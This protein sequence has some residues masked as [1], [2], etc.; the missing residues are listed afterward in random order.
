MFNFFKVFLL[1][2]AFLTF[3]ACIQVDTVVKVK[4]DGSGIGL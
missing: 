3:S 1:S 4:T 2:I